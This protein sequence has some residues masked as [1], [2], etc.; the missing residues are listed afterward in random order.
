MLSPK[1]LP[2][3]LLLPARH[4]VNT[5]NSH[6]LQPS[7]TATNASHS[8]SKTY[9]EHYDLFYLFFFSSRGKEL[10]CMA[11]GVNFVDECQL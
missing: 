8:R 3:D 6:G 1:A 2:S 4:Q 11:L 9:L 5:T 10:N 7:R